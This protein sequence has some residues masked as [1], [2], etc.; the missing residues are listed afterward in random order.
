MRFVFL[1]GSYVP[2]QMTTINTLINNYDVEIFSFSISKNYKHIPKNIDHLHTSLFLEKS[3]EER[4][5]EIL[6][7][8]PDAVI[9]SGWMI[10]DFVWIC[11]KIKGKYNF[12][13]IGMSDTPWYGTWRQKVNCLISRFHLRMTFSHLWVAGVKQYDY[14]RKL[15]FSNDQIIF[16]SLSANIDIFNQIDLTVK[17]KKYP[18]NFLF[19]GRYAEVKGLRNLMKAWNSVENKKGWKFTLIG[20]GELRTELIN[21]GIFEVKEYM[22]Q[23]LLLKEMQDAGC[24]V[25]PS[26]LEPW[27]LVIHEA[28][29]AGLPIICTETCG[30]APHF[31]I[32]N[33]NGFKIKDDSVND[34]KVQI[35]RI[36]NLSDKELITFSR[37]SSKL[38][39]SINPLVQIASLM[40]LVNVDK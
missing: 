35:E 3:K 15:G 26:L 23:E 40:Q 21:S 17:E 25:L 2:H 5:N 4:L 12:P 31:V 18:R 11:K 20:A 14:A 36:I 7:L 24:F 10:K 38:S 34:L 32:N 39:E 8:K 19:I 6:M 22:S 30:A 9:V 16:N 33:Y 28:A 13:V 27:A 37:R 1:I 29:A